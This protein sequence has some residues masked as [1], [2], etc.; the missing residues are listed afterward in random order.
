MKLVDRQSVEGTTPTVYI[1]HR[2]YRDPKSGREK[3][4]RTWYCEY[5]QDGQRQY[6]PLRT[7]NRNAAIR[8]VHKIISRIESSQPKIHRQR[9]D[10]D[11]LI[12][13]YM[14]F[15]TNKGRAPKTLE[16]Y[17]YVL[18]QFKEWV[19]SHSDPSAA[20]FTEGMFWQFR[21]VMVDQKLAEGTIYDRLIIIKQLFRWAAKSNR[22]IRNPIEGAEV[23]EPDSTVQPCLPSP[24]TIWQGCA[25]RSVVPIIR[26]PSPSS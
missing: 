4:S 15:I 17:Q 21:K 13:G 1:G 6:E 24:T 11:V 9:V 19:A 20:A 8:A 22:I 7:T 16:K 25:S 18:A 10:L 12:Q 23:Q 3:I 14:N 5:C 2:P 26:R